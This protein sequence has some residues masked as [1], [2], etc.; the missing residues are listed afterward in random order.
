[1]YAHSRLSRGKL[2]LSNV[3]LHKRLSSSTFN[4]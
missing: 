3:H 2:I 1:M 4:T